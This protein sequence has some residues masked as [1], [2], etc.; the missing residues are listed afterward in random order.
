MD[1]L[2]FH[3]PGLIGRG[4]I[5]LRGNVPKLCLFEYLR[6]RFLQRFAK[7]FAGHV[8]VGGQVETEDLAGRHLAALCVVVGNTFRFGYAAVIDENHFIARICRAQRERGARH[9]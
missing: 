2:P 6:Q 8:F 9:E 1:D 5:N 3:P 7:L 4:R